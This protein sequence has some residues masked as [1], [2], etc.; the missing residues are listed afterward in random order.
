MNCGS[1]AINTPCDDKMSKFKK[2][3]IYNRL[4]T[5]SLIAGFELSQKVKF[6]PQVLEIIGEKNTCIIVKE[7]I[8]PGCDEIYFIVCKKSHDENSPIIKIPKNKLQSI[9]FSQL[10]DCQVFI[11]CKIH[12]LFF[13]H[14]SF[15]QIAIRCPVVGM[16]EFYECDNISLQIRL[17]ADSTTMP[18]TLKLGYD[19]N[20]TTDDTCL[21]LLTRIEN[22]H[23]IKLFQSNESLIYIIKGC[24][25]ISGT[26][27]DFNT[28]ERLDEYNLSESLW[29]F[30]M[31]RIIC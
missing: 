8:Y 15:S 5:A 29:D 4:K 19:N 21:P 3:Q 10:Y 28:K 6:V 17:P 20:N 13:Q 24:K 7:H 26:I 12:R 9:Y 18:A 25:N 11:N 22:C 27:I 31:Q 16:A 30:G 2:L 23:N 14:C 1:R